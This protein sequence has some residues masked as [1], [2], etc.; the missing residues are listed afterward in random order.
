[1]NDVV[2]FFN[3]SK[4]V[5]PMPTYVVIYIAASRFIYQGK[6][7]SPSLRPLDVAH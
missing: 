2:C 3:F 7:I 5:I 1:M 6:S 4:C